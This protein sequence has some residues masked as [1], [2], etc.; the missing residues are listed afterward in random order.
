MSVS[1]FHHGLASCPGCSNDLIAPIAA[2]GRAVSCKCCGAKFALPDAEE[3]LSSAVAHLLE[4]EDEREHAERS[5][6]MQQ[7]VQEIQQQTMVRSESTADAD[8]A[9]LG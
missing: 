5:E 7:V 1:S 8:L 2:A 9:W 4:Q 3:L 6:Q